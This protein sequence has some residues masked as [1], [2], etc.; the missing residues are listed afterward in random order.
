MKVYFG[1]DDTDNHESPYGTGK[2]V[3]WFLQKIPVDYRCLG[4]IRQQLL[5]CDGIPYTPHSS[6]VD[7]SATPCIGPSGNLIPSN[8]PPLRFVDEGADMLSIKGIYDMFGM[9]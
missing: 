5:V 3:R 7:H 6:S 8:P 2:L 9:V 1:F 4:V